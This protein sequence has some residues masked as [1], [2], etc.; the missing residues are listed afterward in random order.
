MS[1]SAGDSLPKAT[2]L[3][4]TAEGPKPVASD[5]LFGKGR[6]VV[7]AMPGAFTGTC[8][9]AHIPSIAS[10]MEGIKAKGVTTVAVVTVN[11]PFVVEAWSKS[12]GANDAGITMLADADGSFTK[13]M[14][15]EF[16]AATVGLHGRS[17]R[18]AAII[19]DGK[20]THLDVEESPGTCD[21]TG[22]TAILQKL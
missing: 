3:T 14:G 21:M 8:T 7:F 6:A 4:P 17:R 10:A 5:E 22:G 15:L 19:E 9:T 11:D 16:D 18:Y 2:F 20:V 13:A 12:T 1:I